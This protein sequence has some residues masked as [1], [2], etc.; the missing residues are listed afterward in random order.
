MSAIL[1]QVSDISKIVSHFPQ[2]MTFKHL[3]DGVCDY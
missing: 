3:T 2:E 1:H